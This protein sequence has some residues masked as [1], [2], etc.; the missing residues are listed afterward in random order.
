VPT[1]LKIRASIGK[2]EVSSQVSVKRYG[3]K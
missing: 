3:N 1:S 2:F